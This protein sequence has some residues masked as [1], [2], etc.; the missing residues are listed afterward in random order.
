VVAAFGNIFN[1]K[2]GEGRRLAL[3]ST[4]V[5]LF[6]LGITWAQIVIPAAF[7]AQVGVERLP[8]VF[9]G[10][11]L[12]IIVTMM[13]Y[14]AFVDRY[15]HGRLMVGMVIIG[16]GGIGIGYGLLRFG[17]TNVGFVYLYL[18]F[19]VLI[20]A[21][22]IH[23]GTYLN[24]FFDAQTAKRALPLLFS[25]LRVAVIVAGLTVPL[26]NA[27]F[28]AQD[29]LLLWGAAFA[30]LAFVVWYI[31]R[32][33]PPNQL[34]VH[35]AS[36]GSSYIDNVRDGFRFVF[37]APFLRAMMITAWLVIIV[38]T[39][40]NY[41]TA[42]IFYQQLTTT[43][44]ISNFTGTLTALGGV[45]VLPIQLFLYSR[46]V[47][48]IGVGNTSLLYPLT[49]L[50]A[51]GLLIMLPG[52][53]WAAGL[54][55][56]NQNTL[57]VAFRAITDDLLYN[58]VPAQVKG[59]ARAAIN[60]IVVPLGTLVAGVL[61]LLPQIV[62]ARWFLPVMLGLPAISYLLGA[63]I[64]RSL[65][66][67]ALINLL[68][69]ENY[70]LILRSAGNL[71]FN[72]PAT[73][74]YL[75]S[76]LQDRA[77]PNAVIITVSLLIEGM[78]RDAVPLLEPLLY[79]GDLDL[80]IAVL[81]ALIEAHV[82][83]EAMRRVYVD[84]LKEHDW[85]IRKRAL[86]GLEQLTSP[87]DAGYVEAA[88][89]LLN[90]EDAEI[91]AQ[92]IP[93]LLRTAHE[94]EARAALARLVYSPEPALRSLGAG[95]LGRVTD[96]D[97][98]EMLLNCL[99]DPVE[100]VHLDAVMSLE[101]V[102]TRITVPPEYTGM[103]AGKL[104]SLLSDH[105]VRTRLACV[106][107]A[108][109][110]DPAISTPILV[111]ALRDQS[112]SVRE[113]AVDAL[114]KHGESAVA[115]LKPLLNAEERITRHMAL[116][117]LTRIRRDDFE[118][119]VHR[120]I[121]AAIEDVY[122]HLNRLQPLTALSAV[123]SANILQATIREYCA[124][125]INEVFDLIGALFSSAQVG[126]VRDSLTRT[127]AHVRA[128]AM[129]AL[130]TMIPPTLAALL[131]PLCDPTVNEHERAHL[132]RQKYGFSVPTV[133]EVFSEL[134]SDACSPWFRAITAFTLGEMTP[135]DAKPKAGRGASLLGIFAETDAPTRVFTR[136]EVER[137]LD[138]HSHDAA[139]DVRIAVEAAR[140]MLKGQTI[141]DAQHEGKMLSAV[142]KVVFLK[143]VPFFQGMTVN[144]LKVLANV[145]D[146]EL[147]AENTVIYDEGSPGGKLYVIVSGKV[148][149]ER[150]NK[151]TKKSARIS[152]LETRS[153]F[154][155]A[156][157]F[158]NSPAT[159]TALALSETLTLRLRYEP[160][161]ALMQ[162]YPE[163]SL[164]LIKVLSQ[165]LRETGEQVAALSRTMSRD[166][167]QV[168]DKL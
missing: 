100:A 30:G 133:R 85:R 99:G 37:A 33:L 34:P 115:A 149:I 143:G 9:I 134:M 69:R 3:L 44:Q 52:S 88:V 12:A 59:R 130:E 110:L 27:V 10:D 48:R 55:F 91:R 38:M 92:V 17:Y 5:F 126:V 39:I 71:N 156:T 147:F 151:A 150:L 40:I 79:N 111:A 165:R 4:V 123:S 46:I 114:N 132:G 96:A 45:I 124:D 161:V 105:I 20:E 127:E 62:D 93:T 122:L 28:A 125:L 76:K 83:G 41:Q 107:I 119:D 86:L 113:A 104:R 166:L 167:H 70:T 148:G 24:S 84:L 116:I 140:R 47:A 118:T 51:S 66:G 95:V 21:I 7:V 87:P 56:F 23:M 53:L 102:V 75:K 58:A 90:D 67:R 14:S 163:L 139:Q 168:Y 144:Q 65:Y 154:G 82:P 101:L 16:L 29:I 18:L 64:V 80:R 128:N 78:G 157:L 32:A 146:E 120:A 94:V 142:E 121:A 137:L 98:L 11:A 68:E 72:D 8:Y 152:T 57:N 36:A 19:R 81:D 158:D 35:V 49:T 129:E 54:A 160:L 22:S 25:V 6:I 138:Q 136:A 26:L 50:T 89:A 2:P 108:G 117:P 112:E 13:L 97:Y 1:I 74:N 141:V 145:C 131:S 135:P 77:D 15:P 103:L 42:Q 106:R 159:T 60:G 153:Y 31:P 61:L 162:E 109:R 63:L 155:E 73:L 164:E 43:A